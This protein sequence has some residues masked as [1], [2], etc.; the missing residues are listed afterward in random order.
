MSPFALAILKECEAVRTAF[1]PATPPESHAY[2]DDLILRS[3][4]FDVSAVVDLAYDLRERMFPHDETGALIS[5]LNDDTLAFLPSPKTWIE[6]PSRDLGGQAR[7]LAIFIQERSDG[8][9]PGHAAFTAHALLRNGLIETLC[10]PC[11]FYLRGVER[12]GLWKP[13]ILGKVNPEIVFDMIWSA[14]PLLAIIN[15]PRIIDRKVHRAHKGLVREMKLHGRLPPQEWTEIVL[16]TTPP[17]SA[18]HDGSVMSGKKALHFCRKHIRFRLGRLEW[19][20]AHWRGDP[21]IGVVKSR[22][23]VRP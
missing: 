13:K 4:V 23:V 17:K 3:R 22:Y 9:E 7:R 5:Q 15:S 18:H 6:W 16:R 8:Q 21:A 14:Y 20:S 1:G 19:V 2:L 11:P 12:I 10:E